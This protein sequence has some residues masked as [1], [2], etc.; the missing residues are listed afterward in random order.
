M[1]G[2]GGGGS[3]VDHLEQLST[4]GSGLLVVWGRLILKHPG[5]A[6]IRPPQTTGLKYGPTVTQVRLLILL[7]TPKPSRAF[8]RRIL[9]KSLCISHL[10]LTPRFSTRNG[11]SRRK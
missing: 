4:N 7:L 10:E 9:R 11:R 3:G 8:S 5:E 1:I 6:V 2:F